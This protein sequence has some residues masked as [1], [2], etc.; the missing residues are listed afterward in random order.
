LPTV[1]GSIILA[2]RE[3]GVSITE[4]IVAQLNKSYHDVDELSKA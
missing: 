2:L 3:S 1:L 4:N